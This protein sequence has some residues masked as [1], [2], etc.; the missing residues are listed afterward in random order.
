MYQLFSQTHDGAASQNEEFLPV[1][2]PSYFDK[3][4]VN[5]I[6]EQVK[7]NEGRTYRLTEIE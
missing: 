4:A 3:A 2:R 6:G 7:Y 1:G 5:E